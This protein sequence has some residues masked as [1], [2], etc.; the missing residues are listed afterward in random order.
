MLN[1]FF[2]HHPEAKNNLDS[3]QLSPWWQARLDS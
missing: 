1:G 2:D 3:I